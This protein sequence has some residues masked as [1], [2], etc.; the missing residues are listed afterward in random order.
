MRSSVVAS[1]FPGMNAW[2]GRDSLAGVLVLLAVAL[3]A[4]TPVLAAVVDGASSPFFR[5]GRPG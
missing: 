3:C 2:L 4:F 1:L 5:G